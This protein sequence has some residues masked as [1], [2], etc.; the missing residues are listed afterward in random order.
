MPNSLLRTDRDFEQVYLRHVDTVFRVCYIYM[1]HNKMDLEDAVQNTFVKLIKS[2]KQFECPEHEKAWLIVT[3]A[4]TCKNHLKSKWKRDVVLSKEIESTHAEFSDSAV[5]QSVMELPAKYK[6]IIY[7]Y[8]YEGYKTN[9]IAK[10][11]KKNAS[12]VR[13]MLLRAR[14]VLRNV[15]EEA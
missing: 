15:L 1:K 10:I 11:L 7:L 6:T 5:I 12:T 8:Y 3:A 4:N 9:E 14:G 13:S 2:N